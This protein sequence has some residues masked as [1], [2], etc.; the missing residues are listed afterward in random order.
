MPAT[1][2]HRKWMRD[3]GY[4]AE[5]EA[6]DEEFQLG[7]TL[8]EART[9]AGLSQTELAKRMKTSQS[10]IAR[11]ESGSV[12]PSTSALKRL[13]SATG[14]RLKITFEPLRTHARGRGARSPSH[15]T[16]T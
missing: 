15:H 9:R 6:L 13:A 16:S 12:T 1:D 10:Y 8:I 5:Y 14:S 4:R 11:L 7:K 3:P 2:L